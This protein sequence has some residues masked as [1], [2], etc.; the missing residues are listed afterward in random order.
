[1]VKSGL[2]KNYFEIPWWPSEIPANLIRKSM[3][4]LFRTESLLT[5]MTYFQDNFRQIGW[6]RNFNKRKRLGR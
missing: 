6:G 5:G 2:E 1:M 3:V 4:R